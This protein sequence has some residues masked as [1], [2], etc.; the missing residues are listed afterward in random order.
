MTHMRSVIEE[1][2]VFD[3]HF[4]STV[5]DSSRRGF[6][7]IPQ[8]LRALSYPTV[9]NA[10]SQQHVLSFAHLPVFIRS[11]DALSL[12]SLYSLSLCRALHTRAKMK[13]G[14]MS[15]AACGALRLQ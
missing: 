14:R 8:S 2:A 13:G 4:V 12:D 11:R 6:S 15:V 5:R 7:E 1:N 9:I 10:D 3:P